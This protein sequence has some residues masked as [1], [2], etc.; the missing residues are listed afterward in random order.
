MNIENVEKA[1]LDPISVF[2]RPDD[3]FADDTLTRDQKI[4]ILRRWEYDARELEVAEEENMG[5]GPPDMLDQVLQVLHR[6]GAEVDVE[7]SPP[8]KQGGE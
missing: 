5:G 2:R 7:H 8:T 3:V 4:R 1:L 6:L